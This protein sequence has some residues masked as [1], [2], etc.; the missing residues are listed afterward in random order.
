MSKAIK[1]TV[2]EE[3]EGIALERDYRLAAQQVVNELAVLRL[4]E[5]GRV[6]TG[7]ASRILGLDRYEFL[8]LLAKR[9]IPVLNYLD[10]EFEHELQAV[11]DLS[12][13]LDAKGK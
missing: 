13:Q 11:D 10:E 4:L 6:S 12:A 1:F 9:G 2:P 7:Y 8:D 5:Q 3:V